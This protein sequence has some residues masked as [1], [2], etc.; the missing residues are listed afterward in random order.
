[1]IDRLYNLIRCLFGRHD[2]VARRNSTVATC[3]HCGKISWM[4]E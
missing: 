1:M 2:W 3:M 4:E